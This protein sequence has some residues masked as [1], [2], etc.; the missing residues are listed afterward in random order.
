MQ[1][2]ALFLTVSSVSFSHS[3]FSTSCPF[4][5][6]T[7]ISL[8]SAHLTLCNLLIFCQFLPHP[9]FLTLISHL[10]CYPSLVLLHLQIYF[11]PLLFHPVLF[12]FL[13]S[14]LSF[15]SESMLCLLLWFFFLFF[16]ACP[17]LSAMLLPFSHSLFQPP[18]NLLYLCSVYV[19]LLSLPLCFICL[20]RPYEMRW[21]KWHFMGLCSTT[22]PNTAGNH[23]SHCLLRMPLLMCSIWFNASDSWSR[24]GG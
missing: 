16:L 14:L 15:H 11:F 21:Y 7:H 6:L 2:S 1:R 3:L 5:Y 24:R 12:I 23:K 18:S 20:V 4:F 13:P 19:S 17:F 10:S 8:Y 9:H 22:R